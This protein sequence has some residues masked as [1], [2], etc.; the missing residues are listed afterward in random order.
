MQEGRLKGVKIGFVGVIY[1][2]S[3]L[4]PDNGTHEHKLQIDV[5][6]MVL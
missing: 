6:I 2:V 1:K 5:P 3:P 4:Y